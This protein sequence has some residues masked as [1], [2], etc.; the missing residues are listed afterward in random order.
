MPIT[1]L[2]KKKI[3]DHNLD[4]SNYAIQLRNHL[5]HDEMSLITGDNKKKT[6][7]L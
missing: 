4:K 6:L 1:P 3:C 2:Y 7:N 5:H